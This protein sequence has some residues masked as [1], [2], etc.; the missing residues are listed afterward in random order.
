MACICAELQNTDKNVK[1]DL[2][3]SVFLF[4]QLGGSRSN[5]STVEV[6]LPRNQMLVSNTILQS[7][8]LG[9]LREMLDSR[10]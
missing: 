2:N 3:K 10:T 7:K 6:R 4:C 9:L 8:T 1:E 5:D